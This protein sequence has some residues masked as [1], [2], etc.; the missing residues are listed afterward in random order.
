MDGV[1]RVLVALVGGASLVVPLI[2]M[3]YLTS[4]T[5]RLIIVSAFVFVFSI[6]VGVA[7]K[8]TNQ[9]VLGAT[10]AYAAVLVVFVGTSS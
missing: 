4:Q 2:M 10:A 7:T 3:T 6:L 8:G 1:A 9:E 5:A